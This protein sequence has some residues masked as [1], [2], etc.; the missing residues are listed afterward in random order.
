[1]GT[2]K[3]NSKTKDKKESKLELRDLKPAKE[4]K[5]GAAK[6]ATSEKRNPKRTAEIDFM[7]WD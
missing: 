7:G 4:I 1:M 3:E 2:E 5:G 6:P